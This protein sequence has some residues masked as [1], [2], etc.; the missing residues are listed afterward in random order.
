MKILR[1]KYLQKQIGAEMRSSSFEDALSVAAL[2]LLKLP[3]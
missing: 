1:T 3:A 2:D